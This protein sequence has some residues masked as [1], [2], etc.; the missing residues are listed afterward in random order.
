MNKVMKM[1]LIA[2][3]LVTAGTIWA[4]S[5]RA[6]IRELLGT[7]EIRFP[8]SPEWSAAA[9]GQELERETLVST[10]FRSEAV[11]DLGNSILRVRPLSRLS[12]G[13]L[14]AAAEGDR[15]EVQLRAG[16][17]R[18]DVNAPAA[19][20]VNFT[21]RSPVATASVR[22]TVFDFDTLNL[23]VAE[24][25][26]SFSGADST[27]VYVAAGQSSSPDPTSGRTSAPVETAALMPLPPAGVEEVAAPPPEVIPS[28]AGAPVNL[29]ITW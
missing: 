13:E 20:K 4:Q 7:V 2:V 11:L 3:L 26:V 14:V 25:T 6:V 29:G 18:A 12:L 23:R 15:I 1:A 17:I 27:A 28:F 5:P 9:V 16:R 8:G 22:G 10:G 21:V 19:G 24:G